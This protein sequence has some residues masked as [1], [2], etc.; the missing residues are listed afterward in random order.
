[1]ASQIQITFSSDSAVVSSYVEFEIYSYDAIPLSQLLREEWELGS[2]RTQAFRIPVSSYTPTANPGEATA[3]AFRYWFNI[4]YNGSGAYQISQAVNVITIEKIVQTGF[5][6]NRGFRN[7]DTNITGCT[8][9]I[10]NCPQNF[11]E[12]TNISYVENPTDKCD[13]VQVEI[14]TNELAE[15]VKLNGLDIAT[16]NTNNPFIYSLPRAI[17]SRFE[18][19]GTTGSVFYPASNLEPINIRKLS[20]AEIDVNIASSIAGATVT[21]LID[22]L[23]GENPIPNYTY[24]LDDVNYQASN[25]FT[26]QING[27][28]TIYVKD[29]WNCVTSKAYDVTDSG[30]K[31]PFLFISK[32]NSLV[33]AENELVDDCTIFRN[34]E[35][36]L[37]NQSLSDVVF[38]HEHSYRDCDTITCQFKS[39]YDDPKVYIRFED[40][41]PN[42]ELTLLQQTSNLN[43][44]QYLDAWYYKYASGK[45]GLYF[46]SGDTYDETGIANGT[47]NLNGNV[48]DFAIVGQ[49][50]EI[51]VLGA[52][53]IKEVVFDSTIQKKVIVVDYIYEGV[54]TQTRVKSIYDILPFEV[55]EFTI[56]WSIFGV[57]L[58]DILIENQ[59]TVNSTVQ[60]LSEN[61]GVSASLENHLAIRY[62]NENNRDIFYKFGIENFIRI[63]FLRIEGITVQEDKINITDLT[64]NLVESS[65]TNGNKFYFDAVSKKVMR[66]LVIALSCENVFINGIGY[67]KNGDI[68]V[69]NISGTNLYE[70]TAEMIN[71][72]I[73]YTNNRQGQQ[74]YSSDYIDFDVPGFI[75]LDGTGLLKS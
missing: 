38:C 54:P 41:S 28:Y 43:R 21:I 70:V 17:P 75:D 40:G 5:S 8:A 55:Y 6:C 67:I 62:Y 25:V 13:F 27:S 48:P 1:M 12:V 52:F 16:G 45:L 2:I 42:Q 20:S 46:T 64:S 39:N 10:N 49:V 3:T 32:A 33:F 4:D 23:D 65:V 56:D 31:E 14:T 30:T 61:I 58:Y 9:S 71:T 47:F 37:A 19:V 66:Q 34:E 51:D 63:P 53:E 69:S 44:F 22:S 18:L 72:N 68:D 36:S 29:D 74:G 7:F 50:V 57:G 59:D 24:S 15:T 60:H 35:N 73:N 26:G 11:Q